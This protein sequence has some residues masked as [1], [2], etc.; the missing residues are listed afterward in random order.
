[1][2]H[3]WERE[4]E[5]SEVVKRVLFQLV[6]MFMF[7]YFSEKLRIGIENENENE[8]RGV[9]ISFF[10][11]EIWEREW[12]RIPWETEQRQVDG[13][14]THMFLFSFNGYF[15]FLSF[16]LFV[17]FSSTSLIYY[18]LKLSKWICFGYLDLIL[19]YTFGLGSI[20]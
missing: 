12:Q 20:M 10:T 17:C 9:K 7:L 8:R 6:F 4:R 1:M 3:W 11:G 14:L 13:N 2:R 18:W 16:L 15:F 19:V 5:W